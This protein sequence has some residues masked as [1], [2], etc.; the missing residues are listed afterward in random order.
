M[1]DPLVTPCWMAG[2]GLKVLVLSISG[3]K[4]PSIGHLLI[5]SKGV[6]D[7]VETLADE[8]DDDGMDEDTLEISSMH[9]NGDEASPIACGVAVK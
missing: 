8:P 5:C 4:P 2:G 3:E 7:G 1:T 6:N 9:E